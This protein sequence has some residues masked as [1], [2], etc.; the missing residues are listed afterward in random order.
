MDAVGVRDLL[1]EKAGPVGDRPGNVGGDPVD[2]VVVGPE[3]VLPDQH[4]VLA[5]RDAQCVGDVRRRLPALDAE[6]LEP[7][8]LALLGAFQQERREAG[9][10]VLAGIAV[11][12]EPDQR[13]RPV[14]EHAASLLDVDQSRR[15]QETDRLAGSIAG[16]AVLRGEVPLGRQLLPC[17]QLACLDRC[18]QVGGDAA[19]RERGG[20]GAG[21]C[22][23]TGVCACHNSQRIC[24]GP[25]HSCNRL[26]PVDGSV[27]YWGHRVCGLSQFVKWL[28][29]IRT[30]TLLRR[31]RGRHSR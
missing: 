25:V 19:A 14:N 29:P 11:T 10:A 31:D 24:H 27:L 21:R 15:F 28:K 2:G 23:L 6:H 3:D 22:R 8:D 13:C 4:R 12:A 16:G 7:A 26:E 20:G 18:P 5:C 30:Q 1:V 9:V 17:G